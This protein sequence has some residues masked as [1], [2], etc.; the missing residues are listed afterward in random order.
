MFITASASYT[1]LFITSIFCHSFE[2][3][4]F[5]NNICMGN[6]YMPEAREREKESCHWIRSKPN[7]WYA[8]R[9]H[10]SLK[11][12]SYFTISKCF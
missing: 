6:V 8:Y 10:D 1:H 11:F 2:F 9:N 7:L 12:Y 3:V 4:S 5:Q